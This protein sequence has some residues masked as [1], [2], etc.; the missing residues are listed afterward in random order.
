MSDNKTI[1][2][3]NTKKCWCIDFSI[4]VIK[5]GIPSIIKLVIFAI[6]AASLF[7]VKDMGLR[8]ASLMTFIVPITLDNAIM[9]FKSIKEIYSIFILFELLMLFFF[10]WWI[11][12]CNLLL[13]EQ[14]SDK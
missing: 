10:A 13:Y 11:W 9:T 7:Y 8:I 5:Y 6:I 4:L 14:C 1:I 3:A 2:T 12:V